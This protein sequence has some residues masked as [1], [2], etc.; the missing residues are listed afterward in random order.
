MATPAE[1]TSQQRQPLRLFPALA[2]WP[3]LF[4]PTREVICSTTKKGHITL[5]SGHGVARKGP[6]REHQ[7]PTHHG[8]THSASHCRGRL[9]HHRRQTYHPPFSAQPWTQCSAEQETGLNSISR[10][11]A[12]QSHTA[13]EPVGHTRVSLESLPATNPGNM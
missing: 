11:K 6:C 9:A 5:E 7:A 2:R 8:A 12:R 1:V 4:F 13:C 10:P 3:V